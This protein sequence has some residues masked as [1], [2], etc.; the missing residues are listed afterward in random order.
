[1]VQRWFLLLLSIVTGICRLILKCVAHDIGVAEA[2][3][4][5]KLL[6]ILIPLMPLVFFCSPVAGFLTHGYAVTTHQLISYRRSHSQSSQ[7]QSR[8]PGYPSCLA[9]K[10]CRHMTALQVAAGHMPN[11]YHTGDVPMMLMLANALPFHMA[12]SSTAYCRL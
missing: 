10:R 6:S 2:F 12:S 9:K 1:M 11:T 3:A 4:M 5:R 7:N 8:S